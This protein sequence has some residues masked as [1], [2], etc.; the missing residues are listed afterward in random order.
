MAAA[1]LGAVEATQNG[2]ATITSLV[3]P[4]MHYGKIFVTDTHTCSACTSENMQG[5]T[6][7]SVAS[8]QSCTYNLLLHR[9]TNSMGY[10]GTWY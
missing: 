5:S 8:E 10:R 2:C 4:S 1:C 7:F 3:D 6:K 9:C